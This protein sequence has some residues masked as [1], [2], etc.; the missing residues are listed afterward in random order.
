MNKK[1]FVEQLNFHN[2]AHH[3]EDHGQSKCQ[4]CQETET[5]SLSSWGFE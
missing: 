4:D 1:I 3:F 5:A 2:D